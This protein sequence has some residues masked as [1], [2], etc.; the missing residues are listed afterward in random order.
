MT[1]EARYSAGTVLT[2]RLT[3]LA[4]GEA[5][6]AL[7]RRLQD[8]KATEQDMRTAARMLVDADDWQLASALM[9]LVI[10]EKKGAEVPAQKGG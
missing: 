3:A 4:Q 9:A 10:C 8:A 2:D 5:E 7:V 1:G 6:R